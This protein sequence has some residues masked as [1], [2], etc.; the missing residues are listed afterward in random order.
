MNRS[1]RLRVLVLIFVSLLLP[2]RGAVAAAML[3]APAARAAMQG[4]V[5]HHD[6]ASMS[7]AAGAHA[8]H[9]EAGAT[10]Q[11]DGARCGT[12]ASGCCAPCMVGPSLAVPAPTAPP[13]AAFP[14]L[15]APVAQF[16]SEGPERPPR[17]A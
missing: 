13:V 9:P 8:G 5:H 14:P 11:D 12:C 17:G 4:S 6:P 10:P 2:V 7:T 1:N 15:Q 16:Q 3:C